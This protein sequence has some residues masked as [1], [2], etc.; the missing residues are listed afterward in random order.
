MCFDLKVLTVNSVSCERSLVTFRKESK[1]RT[2]Y[3]KRYVVV[4]WE[5]LYF[6]S[7]CFVGISSTS[8]TK[9]IIFRKE[10]VPT[11]MIDHSTQPW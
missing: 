1:K 6:F 5:L 11:I 8:T 3:A 7:I 10:G 4:K 2:I 9:K